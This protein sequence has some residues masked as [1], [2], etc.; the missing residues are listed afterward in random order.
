M[1]A[2]KD[3]A[4]LVAFALDHHLHL[5]PTNHLHPTY[6]THSTLQLATPFAQYRQHATPNTEARTFSRFGLLQLHLQ[7]A[8][9]RPRFNTL[10]L[11][12][13]RGLAAVWTSLTTTL[14]HSSNPDSPTI[15]LRRCWTWRTSTSTTQ[16]HLAT[17]NLV[18]TTLKTG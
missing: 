1:N 13:V 4:S 15:L 7:Q 3:C 18:R 2:H 9:H 8:S 16:H 10:G 12:V 14:R 6:L 17:Q 5:L 11:R